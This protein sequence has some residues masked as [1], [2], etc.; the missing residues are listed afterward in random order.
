MILGNIE[1]KRGRVTPALEHYRRAVAA[2]GSDTA[3][4]EQK[5][6]LI[7]QMGNVAAAVA[8]TAQ[9]ATKQKWA[10]DA[11]ATYDSLAAQF[12]GT[13]EAALAVDRVANL[14]LAIGDTAAVRASYAPQLAAPEKYGYQALLTA[15]VNASRAG[16]DADALRLFEG[17]L[18][19]NPYNR[20]ALYNAA[21]VAYDRKDFPK[22]I[23]FL[24]RLVQLDAANDQA[25]LLYAHNYAGLNKATKVPK[26]AKAYADSLTKYL[27]RSQ[28]LPH[29]VRFTEWSNT[30]ARSTLRGAVR[31]KGTAARAYNVT[32]EFLDA[33]G[34]VVGTQAVAIAS[35]AP[36]AEGTFAAE[37]TAPS[38]VAF[39]YRVE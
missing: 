5:R 36:G 13:P 18:T 21:L 8:D 15:G 29:Q 35:V 4:A 32:I 24:D 7:L 12:A 28:N 11:I 33:K 20:D 39:R 17:T 19:V 30:A 6:G 2:A 38:A 3:F 23:G 25:W 27:E 22:S 9:G 10:R 37:T 1:Y 14:R 16:Q 31:N 26:T 34:T